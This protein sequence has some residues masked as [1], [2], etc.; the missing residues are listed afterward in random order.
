M[1][2]VALCGFPAFRALGAPGLI[3]YQGC[4]TDS[5]G[6]A[7]TTPVDVTFTFWDSETGGD[8]LGAFSDT[9]TV[10][11]SAGGLFTTLIG[12]APGN[13][14]PDT[15]FSMDS[16]WLNVRV[17]ETDLTPRT[18][19]VSSAYSIQAQAADWSTTAEVAL[20]SI[21]AQTAGNADT[22]DGIHA[23]LF[24][25]HYQGIKVVAKNGGDYSTIGAALD[26]IDD[27]SNTRRYLIHVAPGV[28][29]EQVSMKPYV[30]VEGSGELTTRITYGGSSSPSDGTVNGT[31]ETELR[32]IT[33]ENTGGADYAIAIANGSDA[34]RLTHVTAIA[35]GAA[36]TGYGISNVTCEPV[37]RHVTVSVSGPNHCVGIY[38]T[39]SDPFEIVDAT[40]TVSG[41]AT[42]RGI[43]SRSSSAGTI[44]N[45]VVHV[46][47]GST[48]Y[49]I[50]NESD[51]T[52]DD[53]EV[54]AEG[55]VDSSTVGVY[56]DDT[57]ALTDVNVE[58]SGGSTCKGINSRTGTI[59]MNHVAASASG[60]SDSSYAFHGSSSTG[61]LNDVTLVATEGNT[62]RA[63]YSQTAVYLSLSHVTGT[64]SGASGVSEGLCNDRSSA[65]VQHSSFTGTD[66]GIRNTATS[67]TYTVIVN[68]SQIA[69]GT[70]AIFNDTEF[71][72]RIGGSLLH[73]GPVSAGGGTCA[74]AGVWDEN[75]AFSAGPVC[76]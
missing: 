41:G 62:N 43:W 76:P 10:A 64:A 19:M 7:I 59:A 30:D 20:K 66:Y 63:L 16:V 3:S 31:F 27:A 38:N 69:G 14:I 70:N 9:D 33:V 50:Y 60:S 52:M 44:R 56:S 11:P 23:A 55:P 37:I 18:R 5:G 13:P 34:T 73:G 6:E 75:Y 58:A 48:I 42:V 21:N 28:Y 51:L 67:G 47:G 4:L 61:M 32:F 2:V 40:V 72:V 24:Q 17:G 29:N 65:T 71:T 35:S 26:S 22:V 74:C 36:S 49:G 68:N 1:C 45:S 8:S 39:T 46:S 12:D 15:L 57:I 54:I 25:R 53:V